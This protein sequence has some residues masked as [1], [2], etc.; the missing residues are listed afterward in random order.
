VNYNPG[1]FHLFISPLFSPVFFLLSIFYKG[2]VLI[3]QCTDY[4]IKISNNLNL[5]YSFLI[6]PILNLIS[7]SMIETG[8]KGNDGMCCIQPEEFGL[9]LSKL[10]SSLPEKGKKL[11]D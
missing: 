2:G 5:I 10:I 8:G 3:L 7:F 1:L 11:F 9:I 6:A 4:L